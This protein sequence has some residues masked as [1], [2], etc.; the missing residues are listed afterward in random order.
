MIHKIRKELEKLNI[1]IAYVFGSRAQGLAIKDS[2]MDIGIVFS[3]PV[4]NAD[5]LLIYG[6]LYSLFLTATR[7]QQAE[8]DIVFLQSASLAMQFNAIKYGRV[9]YEISAKFRA[10][11]EEKIMLFHSDFEP[12][13]KEF[14]KMVLARI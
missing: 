3:E 8:I 9:L 4:E 7:E 2:D 11:Y 6:K 12:V 14:D 5:L 13:A 1:G 10:A